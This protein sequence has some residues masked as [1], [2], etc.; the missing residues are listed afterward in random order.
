FGPWPGDVS[1]DPSIRPRGLWLPE[2]PS[3]DA[4]TAPRTAP[5][6]DGAAVCAILETV[7]LL[8]GPGYLSPRTGSDLPAGGLSRQGAVP[9]APDPVGDPEL[10][11]AIP[12]SGT[13]G[14]E[15]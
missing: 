13:L 12:R 8:P 4:E 11:S 14:G 2:P 15:Q 7:S 6:R 1:A 9:D 3:T 10:L 5:A